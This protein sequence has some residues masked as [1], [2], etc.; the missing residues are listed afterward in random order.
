MEINHSG[1]LG[2]DGRMTLKLILKEWDKGHRL[3]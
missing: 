2:L 1:E 3:N